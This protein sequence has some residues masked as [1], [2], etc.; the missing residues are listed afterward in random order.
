MQNNLRQDLNSK[1]LSRHY[2]LHQAR[3]YLRHAKSSSAKEEVINC[4][5]VV[6]R[7]QNDI[8]AIES[9]LKIKTE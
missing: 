2:W 9:A 5:S 8:D 1:I 6:E 3:F 7:L 4:L